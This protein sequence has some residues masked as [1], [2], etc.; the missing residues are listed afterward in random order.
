M[1]DRPQMEKSKKKKLSFLIIK[2]DN[3]DIVDNVKLDTCI[4]SCK[5]GYGDN[6][7]KDSTCANQ[8]A[9]VPTCPC[10]YVKVCAYD[11]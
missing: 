10:V 7:E 8:V 4:F 2:T 11:S 3:K 9:Y 1:T 5:G 6:G